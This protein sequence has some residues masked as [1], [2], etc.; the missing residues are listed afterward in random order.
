MDNDDSVGRLRLS[1]MELVEVE[2][3]AMSESTL[4]LNGAESESVASNFNSLALDGARSCDKYGTLE[5][6]WNAWIFFV[7]VDITTTNAVQNST[8]VF[9]FDAFDAFDA[10]EIDGDDIEIDV[11]KFFST[12]LDLSA[13]NLQLAVRLYDTVERNVCDCLQWM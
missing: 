8:V 12:I 3:S 7:D 6:G 5:I 11:G 13:P 1:R 10:F 2:R 4:R 9:V